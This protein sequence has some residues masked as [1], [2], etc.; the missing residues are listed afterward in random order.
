MG[1]ELE[2]SDSN[3][4]VVTRLA[5]SLLEVG[6]LIPALRGVLVGR[7]QARILQSGFKP[8]LAS[9]SCVVTLGAQWFSIWIRMV[10]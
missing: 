2:D 10:E 7:P 8:L 1:L 5:S 4:G 9:S 6:F 3:S